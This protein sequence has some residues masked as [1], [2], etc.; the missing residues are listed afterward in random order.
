MASYIALIHKDA[1]SDYGVSFPDLPGCVTAGTD[2]DDA[3]A[4][5]AEALALHLSGLAEDGEAIPEPSSLE[6]VMADPE[7][8]DGVAILV[9]AP[10]R[11]RKV[12]RVNVTFPEDELAAIDAK[13]EAFGMTRSGFL[14][15]AA[16]QM[17]AA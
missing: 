6:T 1:G 5:A 2:L 13:A 16:R 10:A 15:R 14:A 7:N 4:M 9:Q 17:H 8:R 3:R 12:V 11:A